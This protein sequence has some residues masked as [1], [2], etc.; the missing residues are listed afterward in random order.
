MSISFNINKLVDSFI[1]TRPSMDEANRML[2]A[3]GQSNERIE[4]YL[5]ERYPA[6]F[7]E[8]MEDSRTDD[9]EEIW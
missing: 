6:L 2:D 7:T 4:K 1:D 5:Y 3:I 9:D 8:Y